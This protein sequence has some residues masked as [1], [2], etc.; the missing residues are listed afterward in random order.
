MRINYRSASILATDQN[1]NPNNPCS[2]E[3]MKVRMKMK[4]ERKNTT[5]KL[6]SIALLAAALLNGSMAQAAAADGLVF[7][8][9]I[10][11]VCPPCGLAYGTA[12]AVG[13]FHQNGSSEAK[14]MQ[15]LIDAERGDGLVLQDFLT[16][17]K[18]DYYDR[19][20]VMALT[21]THLI[22][23]IKKGVEF[24]AFTHGND[25]IKHYDARIVIMK[26]LAFYAQNPN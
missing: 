17:I 13:E 5:M 24:N 1:P 11:A 14:T 8:V 9:A 22:E 15:L 12:L 3:H 10:G 20:E 25:F 18:K 16:S 26:M 6:L 2:K 4:N 19:P 7:T 21:R 23:I